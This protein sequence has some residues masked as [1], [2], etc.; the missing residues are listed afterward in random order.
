MGDDD[1]LGV[2]GVMG[3]AGLFAHPG[4]G[5]VVEGV[6]EHFGWNTVQAV[7]E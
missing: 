4:V 2:K 7:A 6:Q 1:A 5:A 3:G